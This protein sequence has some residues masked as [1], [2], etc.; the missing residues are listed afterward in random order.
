MRIMQCENSSLNV[1]NAVVE[2]ALWNVFTCESFIY[3]FQKNLNFR[4]ESFIYNVKQL[5]NVSISYPVNI[6]DN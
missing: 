5:L 2:I 4:F 6:E 1:N 3:S